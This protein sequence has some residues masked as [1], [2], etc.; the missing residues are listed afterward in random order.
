VWLAERR[1]DGG[2]D[3]GRARR[4]SAATAPALMRSALA[5][6]SAPGGVAL[7]PLATT[8]PGTTELL[9]ASGTSIARMQIRSGRP[10]QLM[11]RVDVS[12]DPLS[13]LIVGPDRAVY[14]CTDPA[15]AGLT[16]EQSGT[17]A[18]ITLAQ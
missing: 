17:V 10:P 3:I 15:R 13:C 1:H 18:R 12:R 2:T 14:F 4:R 5:G 11:A 9:V 7:S 6:A 16:G 8:G